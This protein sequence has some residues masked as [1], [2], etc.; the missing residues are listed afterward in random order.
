MLKISTIETKAERRLVVEGKL[1]RPWIA[2]LRNSWLNALADL[3]G[4][5]LVI[6]LSNATVI[7]PEGEEALSQL[8]DEGASFSCCGVFTRHVL[9]R[10]AFKCHGRSK[11]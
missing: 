7:G 1:I 8:M 6:D 9:K 4:R 3:R 10:L 5:K 11:R 2:E